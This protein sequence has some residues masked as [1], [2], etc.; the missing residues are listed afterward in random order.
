MQPC[1]GA[2]PYVSV[3]VLDSEKQSLYGAVAL[4]VISGAVLRN[5]VLDRLG[6]DIDCSQPHLILRSTKHLIS[7]RVAVKVSPVKTSADV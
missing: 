7:S 5:A 2:A 6:T 1:G 3:F 4:G